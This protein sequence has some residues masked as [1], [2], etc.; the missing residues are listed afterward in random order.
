MTSRDKSIFPYVGG[1]WWWRGNCPD[2]FWCW[3]GPLHRDQVGKRSRQAQNSCWKCPYR[4]PFQSVDLLFQYQG[5]GFWTS[6][7]CWPEEQTCSRLCVGLDEMGSRTNGSSKSRSPAREGRNCNQGSDPSLD[8]KE[9]APTSSSIT[10]GTSSGS[11]PSSPWC[12]PS[13]GR[14]VG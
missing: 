12:R 2:L 5:T 4:Q 11:F 13:S 7:P 14:A 6:W 3:Q 10:T 8:K 9:S 1:K